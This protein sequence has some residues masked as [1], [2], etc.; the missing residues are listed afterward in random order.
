MSYRVL[1]AAAVLVVV[2]A[3]VAVAQSPSLPPTPPQPPAEIMPSALDMAQATQQTAQQ[4]L[5]AWMSSQSQFLAAKARIGE[6]EHQLADA[7]APVGSG[8][9]RTGHSQITPAAPAPAAAPAP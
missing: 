3:A 5:N 4:L 2:A 6:L 8:T 7:K 9:A 1:S